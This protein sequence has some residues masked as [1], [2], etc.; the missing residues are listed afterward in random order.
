M[1]SSDLMVWAWV[2]YATRRP[3]RPG[4]GDGRNVL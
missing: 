3:V 2:A 4:V 1:S